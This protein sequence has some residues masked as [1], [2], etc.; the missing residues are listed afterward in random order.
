MTDSYE[1]QGDPYASMARVFR[2]KEAQ[3][4]LVRG[5][6]TS[7]KPLAIHADGLALAGADLCVNT[8]LLE[9]TVQAT[10]DGKTISMLLPGE[11]TAGAAVLLLTEDGQKYDVLCRVVNT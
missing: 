2:P 11:L 5:V 9:R 6:V 4:R 7:A 10:A 1:I 3:V 8:A